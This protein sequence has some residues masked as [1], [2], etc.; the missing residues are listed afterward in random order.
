MYETEGDITNYTPASYLLV[1]PLRITGGLRLTLLRQD[2]FSSIF[3]QTDRIVQYGDFYPGEQAPRLCLSSLRYVP[4][5]FARRASRLGRH[6]ICI[7]SD[8]AALNRY[9]SVSVKLNSLGQDLEKM[10]NTQA[11]LEGRLHELRQ[12]TSD[13]LLISCI[14]AA[15]LCVYACWTSIWNSAL[16]PRGLSTQLLHHIRCWQR[17]EPLHDDDLLF[18]LVHI[19]KAFAMDT[20]VRYGLD[21]L[22]KSTRKAVADLPKGGIQ[23]EKL[24][25]RFIWSDAFYQSE[26]GWFWQHIDEAK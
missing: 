16:I 18:W 9:Q 8:V 11:L 12:S 13:D 17:V 1:R 6:F 5:G 10:G 15:F 23:A 22:L 7:V 3:V 25:H 2:F 24:L 4:E 26:G 20:H 21:E 19:G 14:I